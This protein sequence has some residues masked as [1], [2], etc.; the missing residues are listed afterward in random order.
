MRDIAAPKIVNGSTGSSNSQVTLE[1]DP[2]AITLHD[3]YRSVRRDPMGWSSF[4]R[5]PAEYT[6][7]NDPCHQ[8]LQHEQQ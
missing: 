1:F 8:L 6:S 7:Q 4:D 5:Y 3:V 2:L